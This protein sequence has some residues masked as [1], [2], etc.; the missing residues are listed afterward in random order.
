MLSTDDAEKD[1]AAVMSSVDHLKG[2]FGP[3]SKWPDPNMT[4]EQD[5]DDLKWHQEEFKKRSSFAYTVMTPDESKCLGC[6]YIFPSRKKDYE[7]DVFLWVRKSELKTGL[8]QLLYETVKKWVT[9]E[10]LFEKVAFPGR[11]IDWETWS[12]LK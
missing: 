3:N 5:I 4:P 7:A 12:N 9:D 10:W 8:D 11:E 1:Y 2:F 6:V